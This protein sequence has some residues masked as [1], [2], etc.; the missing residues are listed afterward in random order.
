MEATEDGQFYT[1]LGPP[2]H[3][4]VET[5]SLLQL[6][7]LNREERAFCSLRFSLKYFGKR[8]FSKVKIESTNFFGYWYLSTNVFRVGLAYVQ[9]VLTTYSWKDNRVEFA[10]LG[11][12]YFL[13]LTRFKF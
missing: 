10:F 5:T 11:F 1:V 6:K 3:L 13:L 7:L 4:E 9:N 8:D 2:S 12:Q